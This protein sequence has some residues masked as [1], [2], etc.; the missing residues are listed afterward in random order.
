MSKVKDVDALSSITYP[1][2]FEF[3]DLDEL[4]EN[5]IDDLKFLENKGI[6]RRAN[7]YSEI[8]TMLAYD[9]V[10]LR[11]M[12]Q[13]R[14]RELRVNELTYTNL[15][16]KEEYLDMKVKEYDDYFSCYSSK[17]VTKKQQVY[18]EN[19]P[20]MKLKKTSVYGSYY[21]TAEDLINLSIL[22]QVYD[23]P[24]NRD[25]FFILTSDV[26][27]CF[28][29]EVYINNLQIS[30]PYKFRLEDILYMKKN[31]EKVFDVMGI[32]SF[33]TNNFVKLLN[34]RYIKI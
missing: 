27:L 8:I 14:A 34:D 22:H 31:N 15:F 28:A 5:V 1:A 12:N 7:L 21:F 4:K 11:F 32:C 6:T 30:N 23:M 33:N 20:I 19:S 13:E 24:D 29:L 16:T 2:Q 3:D 18:P 26:P 17:M 25:F 10:L 9:I